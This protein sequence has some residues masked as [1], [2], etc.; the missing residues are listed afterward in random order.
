MLAKVDE[1][2]I[3][4]LFGVLHGWCSDLRALY[5]RNMQMVCGA[6]FYCGYDDVFNKLMKAG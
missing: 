6:F 1:A 3:L 5:Q 2:N 4:Y